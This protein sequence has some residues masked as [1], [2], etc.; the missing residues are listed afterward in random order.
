MEILLSLLL[1]LLF[2]GMSAYL[3]SIKGRRPHIWFITGFLLGIIGFIILL[4]LPSVK[5][6]TSEAPPSMANFYEAIPPALDKDEEELERTL[7][8][9]EILQTSSW[10]YL[11]EAHQQIGP[12]D[13]EKLA[14]LWEEQK[15]SDTTYLWTEDMTDWQHVSELPALQQLLNGENQ[16]N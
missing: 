14:Q 3:A 11:D 16:Q 8:P 9:V 13:F 15:I 12:I 10:Y 6:R 2:G 1:S 4:F 5:D 7:T